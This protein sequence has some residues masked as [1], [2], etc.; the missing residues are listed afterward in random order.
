MAN[1]NQ[2][3]KETIRRLARREVKA[4]LSAVRGKAGK[5]RHTLASMKRSIAALQ[6]ECKRLAEDLSK[7]LANV[8]APQQESEGPSARFTAKGVRSLRR[9]LGLSRPRFAKLLGATTQSVYNWERQDGALR[10]R[11]TTREA[12]LRVRTFGRR[13]ANAQLPPDGRRGPKPR[14]ARKAA[15]SKTAQTAKSVTT[16]K[17]K[18]RVAR[19]AR[20]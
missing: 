7:T 16:A 2:V 15:A 6:K 13:E 18:R 3:L 4:G 8:P 19:K 12:L 1:L 17:S 9:K 20:K 5:S 11:A 14:G 10:L